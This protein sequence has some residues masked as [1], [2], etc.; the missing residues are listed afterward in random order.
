[1]VDITAKKIKEKAIKLGYEKC[2][3][4]KVSELSD[5]QTKLKERSSRVFAGSFQFGRFRGLAN[6]QKKYPWAKSIIVL[7][8]SYAGYN[9][10]AGFEGVYGKAYMFDGR[11]DEN[12]REFK[13]R[14]EFASFLKSEGLK[15]EDEPKF[16]VTALRWAAYKA[17]VGY[18]RK[19]NFFYTENGSWNCLEA[20]L[21][22]REMELV[23]QTQFDNCLDSCDKCIKACPTGSLSQPYTMSMLKCASFITGMAADKGL[24]VTSMKTAAKLGNC[25]YGCDIC[26][27]VCPFN[28]DK[29]VGGTDFPGLKELAEYMRPE[30]IMAMNYGEIERMLAAKYW[31]ISRKKLWKWK[32]NAL[33]FM[34]NNFVESYREP[35]KL[36]V[37]DKNM[38]VRGFA[39][40]I[41][42]KR[43]IK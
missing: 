39:K 21:V 9:V 28:K 1:M 5:Y 8:T 42:S 11:L 35:I 34:N 4:V 27:S 16:G 30:K 17:G 24:G 38:W 6:P 19:N 36:G 10:P 18:I 29:F 2:G 3:I 14:K 23:E 41:C 20:W 37:N 7:V 25:L 31:Y 43:L 12:S 22:D 40:K 15:F 13:M 26:Q 32:L 33:T